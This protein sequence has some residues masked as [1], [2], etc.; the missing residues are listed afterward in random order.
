MNLLAFLKKP[1][2]KVTA[3]RILKKR[4]KVSLE[5]RDMTSPWKTKKEAAE[6]LR[7]S[8]DEIDEYRTKHI[9]QPPIGK[10]GG[11]RV[12]IH[13]QWLTAC[14]KTLRLRRIG[15]FEVGMPETKTAG[16]SIPASE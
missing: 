5:Q 2:K 3:R 12:L 8:V 10:V 4:V 15:A 11:G 6:Y 7:C 14:E 1:I 16:V 13:I 9:L